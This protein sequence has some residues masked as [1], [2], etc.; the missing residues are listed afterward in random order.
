MP[1]RRA[2]PLAN[3]DSAEARDRAYRAL[4]ASGVVPRAASAEDVTHALQ[5]HVFADVY[6]E[7]SVQ[8]TDV[9]RAALNGAVLR[10]R[11][12]RAWILRWMRCRWPRSIFW[13]R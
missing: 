1:I 3:L 11:P 9:A 8:V 13:R 2:V 6:A 7:P 5:S 12:S 4:A 10:E